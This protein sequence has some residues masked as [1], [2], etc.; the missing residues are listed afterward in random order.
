MRRLQMCNL[1][2]EK[3]VFAGNSRCKSGQQLQCPGL[4]FF[5]H[6]GNRQQDSRERREIMSVLGRGLQVGDS[7]LLV[8]RQS[9]HAKNP[10]HRG[11][12]LPMMYLLKPV[13]SSAS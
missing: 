2:A 10:A 12:M 6:I 9:T 11:A 8:G 7:T 3:S 4:I 5:P 13:A 1:A